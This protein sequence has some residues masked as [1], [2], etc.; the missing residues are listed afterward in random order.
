[1]ETS[2]WTR[3]ITPWLETFSYQ[4]V[5][6]N[7][8]YYNKDEDRITFIDIIRAWKGNMQFYVFPRSY[9]WL[10]VRILAGNKRP[11]IIAKANIR[12]LI[13]RRSKNSQIATRVHVS[14]DEKGK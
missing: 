9:F 1:M 14:V 6:N 13:S 10:I 8:T 7:S 12:L 2:H 11:K 4:D 3:I 5:I